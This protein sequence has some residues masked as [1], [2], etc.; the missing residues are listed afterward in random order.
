MSPITALVDTNI[1][2]APIQAFSPNLQLLRPPESE[3]ENPFSSFFNAALNV[4]TDTNYIIGHSEQ[5]QLD[6]ATGRMHDILSVQMAMGR[7][8]DALTFTSQITTRIIESYREIM[9]MQI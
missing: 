3:T 8:N 2:P 6:F 5:L 1:K 4:V 7:A 9:R